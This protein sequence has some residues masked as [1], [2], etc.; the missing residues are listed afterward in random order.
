MWQA[1]ADLCKIIPNLKTLHYLVF[2]PES[3]EFIL[4]S[5][6]DK[7]LGLFRVT[8]TIHLVFPCETQRPSAHLVQISSLRQWIWNRPE[9]WSGTASSSQWLSSKRDSQT[10]WQ[11][12][13][14][15]NALL[16]YIRV[17]TTPPHTKIFWLPFFRYTF[18]CNIHTSDDRGKAE[19]KRVKTTTTHSWQHPT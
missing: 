9:N 6:P 17:T 19:K 12:W 13:M 11:S 8:Q 1:I 2:E 5:N 3:I 18:K 15:W 16:A 4:R 7:R 14:F 10:L